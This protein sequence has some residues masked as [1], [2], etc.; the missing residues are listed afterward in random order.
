MD[1]SGQAGR[2]SATDI[3][4]ELAL[5]SQKRMRREI[6][7]REYNKGLVELLSEMSLEEFT[8]AQK[9]LSLTRLVEADVLSN[10]CVPLTV[11]QLDAA[12]RRGKLP[13]DV[14]KNIRA[15]KTAPR[16]TA[17]PP[18]TTAAV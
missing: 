18:F 3:A 14:Y 16:R 4:I 11:E 17:L 1:S 15:R 8:A 12:Y 9:S 13:D 10:I 5:L 2:K 7:H 6:E